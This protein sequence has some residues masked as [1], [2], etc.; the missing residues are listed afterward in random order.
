MTYETQDIWEAAFLL[1]VDVPLLRTIDEYQRLTFVF[2]NRTGLAEH[3]GHRFISS[4]PQAPART[5]I[6]AWQ[7]VSRKVREA[8]RGIAA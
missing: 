8:R 6:K 1:A 3:K 5:L 2:D 4:N 7:L